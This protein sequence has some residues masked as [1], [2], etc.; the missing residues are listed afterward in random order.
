MVDA[1]RETETDSEPVEKVT[2]ANAPEIV[3][4]TTPTE[5]IVTEGPAAFVPLVDDLLVLSNTS[6]DVFMHISTQ[7]YYVVLAGPLV[8]LPF[9]ERSLDL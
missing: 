7:Q 6:D 2:A 9:A 1:T 3:V 5:L 4:A 8:P